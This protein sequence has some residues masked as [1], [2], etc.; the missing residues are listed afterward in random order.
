MHVFV[1]VCVRVFAHVCVSIYY[2]NLVD[3]VSSFYFST[4]SGDQAQDT[5]PA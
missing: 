5:R 1:Y 2:G 4:G 3:S